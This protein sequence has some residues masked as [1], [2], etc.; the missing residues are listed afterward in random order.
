MIPEMMRPRTPVFSPISG[1]GRPLRRAARRLCAACA[2][3]AL[4]LAAVPG[5]GGAAESPE[6]AGV[7]IVQSGTFTAVPAQDAGQKNGRYRLLQ[8]GEDV[9]AQA[10][11]AFGAVFEVRGKPAGAPVVL[12]AVLV[13]PGG[14]EASA[15][16][17]FIPAAIGE[18][19]QAVATFVY[20]WEAV[21]GPW[22]LTLAEGGRVLAG[23]EFYVGERPAP[24]APPVVEPVEEAA[25]ASLAANVAPAP[26]PAV[27]M[28]PPPAAA[29]VPAAPDV[30]APVPAAAEQALPAPVVPAEAGKKAAPPEASGKNGV[31]DTSGKP[32]KPGKPEKPENPDKPV[33]GVPKKAQP[34]EK[35]ADKAPAAPE[36]SGKGPVYL[37]QAGVFS[38]RDSAYAQA[39]RYRAKG[40]PGCVLE[41]GAGKNVRYRV[42]VGRFPDQERA[43]QARRSFVGREGGEALVK[44]APAADVARRLK[45]R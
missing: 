7:V 11:T 38:V 16:R 23:K 24:P 4:C 21:P 15:Q 36:A 29:P 33:P 39:T 13:R 43:A 5:R 25:P 2:V 14:D 8:A 3:L 35:P 45:C 9:P 27:P 18:K 40:Y 12:E 32:G 17:W 1:A 20:A 22:R 6:A 34:P 37:V 44:E 10:G 30:A 26:P 41:E 28:A 19:A 42:V 31:P